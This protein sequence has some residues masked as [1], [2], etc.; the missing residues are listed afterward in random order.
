MCS[1]LGTV[2]KEGLGAD[3]SSTV[4]L[5]KFTSVCSMFILP[6]CLCVTVCVCFHRSSI[7]KRQGNTC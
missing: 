1:A 6:L 7:L 3:V 2:L 5:E 4:L